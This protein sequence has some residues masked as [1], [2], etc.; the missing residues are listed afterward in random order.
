MIYNPL[1]IVIP[2]KNREKLI[3]RALDSVYNQSYRPIRLIV[4]DND[5][6]DGTLATVE[7]W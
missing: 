2:V 5:S 3:L 6:T 1:S 4:V 7:K